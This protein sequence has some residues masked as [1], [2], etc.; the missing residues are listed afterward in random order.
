VLELEVNL[1]DQRT[2]SLQ[3]TTEPPATPPNP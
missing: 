3:P 2:L 1:P